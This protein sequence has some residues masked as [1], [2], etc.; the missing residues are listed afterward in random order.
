MKVQ[1]LFKDYLLDFFKKNQCINNVIEKVKKKW[2]N[3][4]LFYYTK[5]TNTFEIHFL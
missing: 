2:R 1:I 5:I 4:F 3:L